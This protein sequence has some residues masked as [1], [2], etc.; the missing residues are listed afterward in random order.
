MTTQALNPKMHVGTFAGIAGT[1][2][3]LE[4]SAHYRDNEITFIPASHVGVIT[5]RAKQKNNTTFEIVENGTVR[6]ST[7][8]TILIDGYRLKELEFTCNETNAFTVK[9]EQSNQVPSPSA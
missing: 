6:L 8:R 2:Y 1:A 5:I 7:C 3:T 9:V 4:I